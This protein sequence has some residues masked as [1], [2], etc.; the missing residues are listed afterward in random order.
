MYLVD[1]SVRPLVAISSKALANRV[2][3]R[4]ILEL[5]TRPGRKTCATSLGFR[6]VR[7][8][9]LI[10]EWV[11][12][13]SASRTHRSLYLHPRRTEFALFH[14]WFRQMHMFDG[15]EL[16]CWLG[17][18]RFLDWRCVPDKNCP[19]AIMDYSWTGTL[20]VVRYISW[21]CYFFTR[22]FG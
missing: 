22:H 7:S 9:S 4:K 3:I 18:S 2:L 17:V 20:V 13:L 21:F 12:S 8:H 16:V 6:A 19:F 5:Q 10:S 1:L 14:I 15:P 11:Q